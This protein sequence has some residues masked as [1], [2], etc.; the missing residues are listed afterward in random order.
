MAHIKS[1]SVSIELL[2]KWALKA[3]H[4][5]GKG[6]ASTHKGDHC[7]ALKISALTYPRGQKSKSHKESC[8]FGDLM[9]EPK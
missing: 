4:G 7:N 5:Y 6:K 3:K 8:R 2:I 1:D 9:C